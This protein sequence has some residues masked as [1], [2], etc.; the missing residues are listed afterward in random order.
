MIPGLPNPWLILGVVLAFLAFGTAGYFKGRHDNEAAH[1]AAALEAEKKVVKDVVAS[2]AIT[3]AVAEKTEAKV[4]Q[5]REVTR[6]IVK[7]RTE[8][9][10]KKDDAAC[11]IPVGFVLVH[12]AAA[13]GET[14]S[15]P[16]GKLDD[17]PSDVALSDATDVI[18]ENYGTYKELATKYIGLRDWVREQQALWGR[19]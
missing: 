6:T 15:D 1:I 9:V 19:P 16:A 12:D 11:T 13:R 3:E 8:Y 7:W 18:A 4:A 5:V 14:L 2:N 10:T 17:R